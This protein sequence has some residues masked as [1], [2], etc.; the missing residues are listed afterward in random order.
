VRVPCP[1]VVTLA[2]RPEE[3]ELACRS[4]LLAVYAKKETSE[5][6]GQTDMMGKNHDG[7]CRG[8][9]RNLFSNLPQRQLQCEGNMSDAGPTS[10]SMFDDESNELRDMR[11]DQ[12][13]AY[14]SAISN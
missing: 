6:A 9:R 3:G 13:S 8:I 5:Q 12:S 2:A 11:W 1:R 14:I 10:G 7:E 4:I